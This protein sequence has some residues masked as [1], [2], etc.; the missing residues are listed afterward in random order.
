MAGK[1]PMNP[2]EEK[3]YNRAL[4][5]ATFV[6]FYNIAEGFIAMGLGYSDESLTL[7]GFGAD[8]FIEVASNLGV[9][10]MIR[11][12]KQNPLSPKTAFEKTSLQITGY[13]FYALCV[14]LATGIVLAVVQQHKP[15]NT[16]WGIVISCISIAIMWIVAAS[17]IRTGRAL[18]SQP[19]ISDAKCTIICIYMSVVLLLSSFIYQYTGFAYADIIGAAGLIYFSFKE[20]KEALEK[21]EG[22]DCCG[23]C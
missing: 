19:I 8:S 20:G 21:A 11:R 23:H 13:G 22:K 6:F 1:T 3:L 4:A 17:Q 18:H 15:Q 14:T 9:I 7:F 5:F 16:F 12:I 10:Y 2:T